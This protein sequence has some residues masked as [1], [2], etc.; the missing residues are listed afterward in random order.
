MTPL[1]KKLNFKGQQQIVLLHPPSSFQLEVAA[2][3]GETSPVHDAGAVDQI[4]FVLA[5]VI[6]LAD[7][8]VAIQA[9]APKL[10]EDATIWFAYPKKSS[11]NYQCKFNRDTGWAILGQYKLEGVRQVAIDADWSA[12]RFRHV[13]KIKKITRRASMA[14]TPEAKA[15]T[16]N[17]R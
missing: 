2:M 11:K 14:L 4:D 6:T 16:K 8:E 17:K 10:T 12:I 7:I 15:R 13:D 1:F 5:F 3:A 9:V